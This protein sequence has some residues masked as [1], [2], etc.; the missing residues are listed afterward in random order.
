MDV[1]LLRLP[2][3][4]GATYANDYGDWSDIARSA[5]QVHGDDATDQVVI[6]RQ[7]KRR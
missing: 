7:L 2:R 4:G 3:F 5:F 1:G 6:R